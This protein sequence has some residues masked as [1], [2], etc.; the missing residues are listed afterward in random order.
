[1]SPCFVVFLSVGIPHVL[2][3]TCFYIHVLLY[4]CFYNLLYM[5][6][7]IPLLRDLRAR[8]LLRARFARSLARSLARRLCGLAGLRKGRARLLRSRR[9]LVLR[10][11]DLRERRHAEPVASERRRDAGRRR[12]AQREACG[13]RMFRMRGLAF[14]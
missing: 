8:L 2:L 7:I 11:L 1:M 13:A 4:T 10:I 6:F 5:C 14:P 12:A 9:Q 3:Y